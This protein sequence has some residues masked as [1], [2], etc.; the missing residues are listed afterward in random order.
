MT[1]MTGLLGR[2]WS[3]FWTRV[4]RGVAASSWFP[5]VHRYEFWL[6]QSF[7]VAAAM[8][9]WAV[10]RSSFLQ[11]FG[12]AYVFSVALLFI[13]TLYAAVTFGLRGSLPTAIWCVIVVLPDLILDPQFSARLG[14]IWE[15]GLLVILG[16]FV[17]LRVDREVEARKDA[18]RRERERL[19]SEER[20]RSLFEGAPAP[21]LIANEQGI[22]QEA[23]EGTSILVGEP[24]NRLAGR[25]LE[26]VVGDEV[27]GIIMGQA[28]SRA[29][30][31]ESEQL[32]SVWVLPTGIPFQGT[33]GRPWV[34]AILRDVTALE[35]RRRGIEA[36]ARRTLAGREEERR[37]IARELHDGPLQSV[38][39]L[40]RRLAAIEA[41][42]SPDGRRDFAEVS[43]LAQSIADELRRTSRNL[44]PSILDD[45]GLVA[46]LRSEGDL[47]AGQHAL[48]VQFRLTGSPR[49]LPPATELMLL[50]VT[51]EALRN[52]VRHAAAS[53]VLIGLS[54]RPAAVKLSV[55][56]DGRGPG[57]RL[58]ASDLLAAGKL[59][60]VG[61]TER[62]SLLGASC[63]VWAKRHGGT[64]VVVLV[65]AETARRGHGPGG[66]HG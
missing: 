27:A 2:T 16:V 43:T 1:P 31:I 38:I 6:V 25:R 60:I 12:P 62:A 57:H 22:I 35:E 54:Y 47:V 8:I 28:E 24:A 11:A 15:L 23:N 30:Q 40:S 49:Q 45:L 48:M 42:A 10:E 58:A 33:D 56:D 64:V 44:R 19:A 5:P 55:A 18:E 66:R 36:Y 13:P 3:G 53:N 14:K 41:P 9:D 32:G 7:V 29:V 26:T 37:R 50:R 21:I 4:A 39:M 65:P 20:Y 52:V 17:G 61:M 34:Q 63:R 46:A 59:G 51:Q